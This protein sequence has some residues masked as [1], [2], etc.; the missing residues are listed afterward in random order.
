L[1]LEPLL[2]L[3]EGLAISYW[4]LTMAGLVGGLTA[5]LMGVGGGVIVNPMLIALGVPPRISAASMS[6]AI[7]A[8][9]S[10]A[11][12]FDLRRGGV[13]WRLGIWMGACGAV[14]GYGGTILIGEVQRA[15][16]LDAVIGGSYILLLLLLAGQLLRRGRSAAGGGPHPLLTRLPLRYR[17]PYCSVPVSPLLPAIAA[18]AIGMSASLLGVG[19]GVFFVPLLMALFRCD[20]RSVVPASQIATLLVSLAVGT[21][22]L[23]QTG[24]ID[25]RLALVLIVAG[26]I[27]TATGSQLKRHLSGP[28]V[29][30]LFALVLGLG[31]LRMAWQLAGLEPGAGE[32]LLDNGGAG[33]LDAFARWCASAPWRGW[34]GT[35]GLALLAGPLLTQLQHR[36]VE[37]LER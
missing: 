7:V 18:F 37:R 12:L 32:V 20:I 1:P 14:G 26:S 3:G 34:L 23:L 27:G 35:V 24:N 29:Q 9:A 15:A 2:T 4:T 30:R 13:D 17:S 19:G 16:T 11:A 5:G 33:A 10:G 31:A 21:G 22:H 8:N 25:P 36:L 28:V 6:V